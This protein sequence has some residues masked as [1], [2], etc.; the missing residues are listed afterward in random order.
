[1]RFFGQ[2]RTKMDIFEEFFLENG[3]IKQA[4]NATGL[5][6]FL[7]SKKDRDFIVVLFYLPQGD[8]WRKEQCMYVEEQILDKMKLDHMRAMELITFLVTQKPDAVRSIYRES[9]HTGV[10]DLSGQRLLL[11][12]GM[13]KDNLGLYQGLEQLIEEQALL[14]TQEDQQNKAGGTV[15]HVKNLIKNAELVNLSLVILNI[16]I[17][18]VIE[19]GGWK[20]TAINQGSLYWY[21]VDQNQEYYRIFT[22]MFLHGNIQHLFNNMLMLGA[23]GNTLEKIIGKAKYLLVYLL[24]GIVA[25]I[26]SMSYNMEKGL[27]SHSVGSSGAIFGIIGALLFIV[28]CNKGK[29]ENLGKRQMLLFVALS[30][31]GGFMNPGVD[32]GAHVGGLIAGV[33]LGLVVYRKPKKRGVSS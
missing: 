11:F 32:N 24:S 25:A 8:E 23:M 10:I 4:T 16:L 20:K 1:M 15:K 30:L 14:Q 19:I 27:D 31:Y 2:A 21:A 3:F 17:F 29:V 6:V 13:S 12:E 33:I 9:N 18:I 22:S 28:L 7:S 26:V 5:S